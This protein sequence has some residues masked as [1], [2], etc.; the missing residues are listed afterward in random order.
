MAEPLSAAALAAVV[1][2]SM[3]ADPGASARVTG[4]FGRTEARIVKTYDGRALIQDRDFGRTRAEVRENPVYPGRY[5]IRKR[6]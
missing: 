2:L 6:D 1:L 3:P 4:D 5:E